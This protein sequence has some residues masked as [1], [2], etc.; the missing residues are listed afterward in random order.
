MDIL[1]IGAGA[2][3][4][5]AARELSRKGKTVTILEAR[6]RAGGRIHTVKDESFDLPV[7]TGAEF[8]H[9]DLEYTKQLLDEAGIKYTEIG[10]DLFRFQNG[11][12][13]EQH[14]FIE[15]QEE[16]MKKLK[17]LEQDMSV[18]DFLNTYFPGQKYERL[19]KSLNSFVEGYDAADAGH[20]STFALLQELQGEDNEDQYRITGGYTKLIDCLVDDC[21]K[22]GCQIHLSTIVSS[23]NWRSGEVTV[24][25]TDNRS[26]TASKIIITIPIAVLQ[27][28]P[29]E[30]GHITINPLPANVYNAIHALGNTGVIKYVLQFNEPFWNKAIVSD[31]GKP[32]E[33]VGFVFA[34][35]TVPTWWT[36]F[37]EK[38]CMLT[39]WLAGPAAVAVKNATE[40]ELLADALNSLSTIFH[41]TVSQLREKLTGYRII[42]WTIDPFT[43]G[44]YVYERLD[45]KNAKRILNTPIDNTLYFAG[46]GIFE[47][48]QRGTVEAALLS[49]REVSS[50]ITS[51]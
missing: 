25:T 17:A 19:R 4:L 22:E 49:G 32:A 41:L 39:G 20:A 27:A 42:N 13:S 43:R 35:T 28:A 47:G 16:V 1:I 14:D 34:E 44:A 45:S 26:F 15:H 37:P 10:G 12:L 51:K 48:E 31:T 18:N 2:S 50:R 21:E 46:E 36:Q 30:E 38:N 11:Q 8:I 24:T 5:I 40:Q 7:E 23:V 29:G 3:G 33:E 9:G 6:N